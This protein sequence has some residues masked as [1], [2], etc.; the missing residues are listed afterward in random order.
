MKTHYTIKKING[1]YVL[2][3][4]NLLRSVRC[5]PLNLLIPKCFEEQNDA[6]QNEEE[7]K[8]DT[9]DESDCDSIS[10]ESKYD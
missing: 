3:D 7:N 1:R 2:I 6:K 10:V 5:A 4:N 9:E 8:C